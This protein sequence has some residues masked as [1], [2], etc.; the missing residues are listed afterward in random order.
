MKGVWGWGRG[1][2]SGRQ[3]YRHRDRK[4]EADKYTDG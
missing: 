4:R 3:K 2:L 1:A